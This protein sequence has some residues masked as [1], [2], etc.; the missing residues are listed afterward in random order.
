M[1]GAVAEPLPKTARYWLSFIAAVTPVSVNGEL[2]AFGSAVKVSP[3]SV[4]TSH[5]NGAVAGVAVA[6]KI[7]VPP[8][9]PVAL[10]GLTVITGAGLAD[11]LTVIV[12]VALL[13]A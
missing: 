10:D 9:T 7:T 4:L 11:A 2:V 5:R 3:L 6:V 13:A 12:W 8:T 1:V